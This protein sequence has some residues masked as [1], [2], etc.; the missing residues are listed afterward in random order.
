M[1]CISMFMKKNNDKNK[2][3]KNDVKFQKIQ[4][5]LKMLMKT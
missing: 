2:F 5:I 1:M 4:K 3:Y